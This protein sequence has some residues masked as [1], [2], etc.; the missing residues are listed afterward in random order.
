M[1][2]EIIIPNAIRSFTYPAYRNLVIHLA[3]TGGTTGPEQTPE[4][5]E[6]TKLNA[7]RMKRLDRVIVINTNLA[8]LINGLDRKWKWTV[9]VESWCGDGA[10][11][12]PIIAKM[13][14]LN[15]NIDLEIILRDE[16]PE[17]MDQYLTNNSRSI[18]ILICTDKITGMKVGK[19][20]PRPVQIAETS[21]KYKLTQTDISHEEFLRYLHLLYAKD[22]GA[23]IQEDFCQ[24]I[25]F[26]RNY[27]TL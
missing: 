10:Q 22:K 7:Q 20:G 6:A 8:L 24:L 2:S 18:P 1:K 3:E 27:S 25:Q 9:L 17:I 16:N 21:R 19:W 26:W 5:I 12:I 15:K 13:A 14:S 23:S 11:N 4:R